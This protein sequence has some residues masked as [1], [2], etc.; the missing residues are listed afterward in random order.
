MLNAPSARRPPSQC[1]S[2]FA[3][4]VVDM[5]DT[6]QTSSAVVELLGKV[7]LFS[8]LAQPELEKL[9]KLMK[10][11]RLRAGETLFMEGSAGS[12]LYII[13]SGAVRIL[14]RSIDG[15][16]V[17]VA[18]LRPLDVIGELSAL[19]G[20]PRSGEARAAEPTELYM[21]SASSLKSFVLEHPTVAWELLKVLAER[22]RKA[23]EAVADAAFLDVPGRVAKRLIELAEAQGTQTPDGVRIG[24]PLTQEELAAM[25]GATREGVNRALSTF[26]SMG[27]VERRGRYYV[28]KNVEALRRRAAM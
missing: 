19:D 27:V 11:K 8:A 17:Q 2:T 9:A 5:T 3:Y 23:D 12:Y 20:K 15:R 10:R 28:L 22:L 18:L 24:I 21:L 14:T 25:I 6:R 26:A 1:R 7:P 13:A 16:E 4:P